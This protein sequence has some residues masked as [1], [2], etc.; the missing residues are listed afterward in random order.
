MCDMCQ[1]RRC[2]GRAIGRRG[3]QWGKSPRRI[4]AGAFRLRKASACSASRRPPTSLACRSNQHCSRRIRPQL[5]A[6]VWCRR[7]ASCSPRPR[8]RVISEAI[9]CARSVTAALGWGPYA[10]RRRQCGG[11]SFSTRRPREQEQDA[12]RRRDAAHRSDWRRPPDLARP[13]RRSLVVTLPGMSKIQRLR[14]DKRHRHPVV[15]RTNAQAPA[16]ELRGQQR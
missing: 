3:S 12:R 15:D 1:A 14:R 9:K 4:A 5:P 2:A 11:R 10:G 16:V 13:P 6:R 7:R 8:T